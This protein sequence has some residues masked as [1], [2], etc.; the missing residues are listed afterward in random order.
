MCPPKG[1]QSSIELTDEMYEVACKIASVRNPRFENRFKN[2]KLRSSVADDPGLAQIVEGV[3]GYLGDI[4]GSVWLGL[5]WKEQLKNM[6]IRTDLLS[7]RDDYDLIYRGWRIDVKTEDFGEEHARLVEKIVNRKISPA[8]VYGERLVNAE[9]FN[10]NYGKS[11]EI[12]VFS[13]LDQLDPRLA[14][15]WQPVGWTY[16]ETIL[17]LGQPRTKSS[18]GRTLPSPAYLIPNDKLEP[19]QTLLNLST[20]ETGTA[21]PSP[22]DTRAN[23]LLEFQKMV[24]DLGLD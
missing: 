19:P 22:I 7:H 3:V 8:E 5:D 10:E 1:F 15:K 9:Q 24:T 4:G 12:Y 14:K 6:V 2:K 18:S 13:C 21:G 11:A 17:S 16:K 23:L 20:H